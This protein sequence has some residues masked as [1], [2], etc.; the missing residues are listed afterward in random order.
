[1]P[2]KHSYHYSKVLASKRLFFVLFLCCT[3][4][5]GLL[6]Q[7]DSKDGKLK[8]SI[9]ADGGGVLYLPKPSKGIFYVP[10]RVRHYLGFS[11]EA[12]YKRINLG[13]GIQRFT[14]P[15]TMAAKDTAA[16]TGIE[17]SF[18]G[19]FTAYLRFPFSVGYVFDLKNSHFTIEP[20]LTGG[21]LVSASGYSNLTN[22][23]NG[24]LISP[25]DTIL[26]TFTHGMQRKSKSSFYGGVGTKLQYKYKKM[27]FSLKVE[28]F[29]TFDDWTTLYGVYQRESTKHG[30]LMATQSYTSPDRNIILG[31]AVGR[32]F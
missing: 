17:S 10:A 14:Y 8:I 4:L 1:M 30:E 22:Y 29:Q 24:S 15:V 26:T 32:Y 5:Q 27:A 7:S 3:C 2:I 19:E 11:V 9:H 16:M 28:Y 23:S 12:N 18:N 13:T 21:M 20:Y 25:T 6:A 31:L